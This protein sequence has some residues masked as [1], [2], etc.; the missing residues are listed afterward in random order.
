MF[1]VQTACFPWIYTFFYVYRTDPCWSLSSV[2]Q[3]ITNIA[4]NQ[5]ISS[6]SYL[7]KS[8]H[9][10]SVTHSYQAAEGGGPINIIRKIVQVLCVHMFHEPFFLLLLC[11]FLSKILFN[12]KGTKKLNVP[13]SKMY[14]QVELRF[15]IPCWVEPEPSLGVQ[16]ALE[17]SQ[18]LRAQH[19]QLKPQAGSSS[20]VL[21]AETSLLGRG[22]PLKFMPALLVEARFWGRDRPLLQMQTLDV[23][24]SHIG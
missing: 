20:S 19:A 8:W 2:L 7:L 18:I 13:S 22:H 14:V 21:S 23:E 9:Y 11:N 1:C 16:F 5:Q 4:N 10:D 12:L 6:L 24:A 15:Y 17:P 3:S